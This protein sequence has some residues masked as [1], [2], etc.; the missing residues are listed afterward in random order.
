MGAVDI[1]L[2]TDDFN[3]IIDALSKIEVQGS[4]YNEQ[5]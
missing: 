4:R 1:T 2:S 3:E 5:S